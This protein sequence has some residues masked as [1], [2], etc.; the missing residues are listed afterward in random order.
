MPQSADRSMLNGLEPAALWKFFGELTAI[1]RP[2]KHEEKVRDWVLA[3]ARKHGWNTRQDRVGNIVCDVPATP[4]AER[5]PI[6]VLQSHLDMVCEK[7][8][9]V[10]FDFD[11]EPLKLRVIGDELRAAGTT[12]GADNGIGVC[13]MLAIATAD[14]VRRPPLELLFTID[15]ET[16]LTGATAI[17]PDLIRGRRLINLDSEEDDIVYIGCAGGRTTKC[18]AVLP[19]Q[20]ARNDEAAVR[21]TLAGLRGGHSGSEIHHERGN[22][23]KL[24]ARVLLRAAVPLRIARLDGGNKHNAIPREAV[25]D[26]L[27]AKPDVTRLRKLADDGLALLRPQLA[28][29]DE[30]LTLTVAENSGPP[31]AALSGDDTARLIRFI[32]ALPH[33]VLGMSR[34]ITG[35]VESSNNVAVVTST[36]ADDRKSLRIEIVASSR[37]SSAPHL[38]AVIDQVTATA[39]LAGFATETADG[40]PGW[41]PNPDSALLKVCRSVYEREFKQAPHVTAIHAGLECGVIGERVGGIDMISFG[42]TIRDVHSP[43]ENVSIKSVQ[44][45]WRYLKAVLAE[46]AT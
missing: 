10:A 7:N 19:T 16:G 11:R 35:L 39:G 40:Y 14:D 15:E 27:V 36:P 12:L 46:L 3:I 25:A 6:T 43:D 8:S 18:S 21:I 17:S 32:A 31:P 37:S 45:F 38:P 44:K 23:L 9:D 13:A 28:G 29:I 20:P 30:G 34:V 42:P 26:L 1:P 4:G 41:Q 24:L 33:G 2:S 5:A 22:S